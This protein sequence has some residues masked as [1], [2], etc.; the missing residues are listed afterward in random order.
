MAS[1][2]IDRPVFSWVIAI[3]IMLAG[4]LSISKIP[5]E[6]YPNIAPPSVVIRA[7]YPGASS[8][9]IEN[10]VTQVIEQKLTG[11]DNLRYFI[12]NSADNSSRITLTFEPGT[13]PNIAQIQTQNKIQGA[14]SSLP[15]QVQSQGVFVT[16]SNDSFLLI[17]GLY[18]KDGSVSQKELADVSA[19]QLQD[20]VARVNGVGS[21]TVFGE[22][23]AIRIWLDPNKLLK[24]K[25]TAS[26]IRNA[27][28]AQN[29]DISAGQL[30]G[31]PATENQKI[32][33]AIQVQA[34]LE[35]PE[36]FDKIILKSNPD[37]SQIKL[38]DVARVEMGSQDYKRIVRYKRLPATGIAV[39]LASG[40]NA[41]K[42]AQRVKDTVAKIKGS[43]PEGV[44]VIYPFDTTPFIKISIR[45]VV[46]TLIEAIILVFLVMLLF[47]Q[48]LR[49][50]FIPTIAV[51]V[52]LLGTFAI[53]S[54]F[55]FSINV[56]TMFAMVL[57]IGLL[58]DDA[59]VVVEN[60]ERIMS[61]EGLPP[62][63]AT[64]KSMQQITPALIGIALVLSSVF[65]PMAFFSGA[66][67]E[68]YKQFSITIVSAMLLS[69]IVAIILSP[70]LCATLL[71]S[72]PGGKRIYSDTGFLGWFNKKFNKTRDGYH[73]GA[74]SFIINPKR[75]IAIYLAI[76]LVMSIMFVRLPTAFLPNE[77]QGVMYLLIK[78]PSGSPANRTLKSVKKVEDYF[79]EKEANN[80]DHLF[81]VTGF[82]FSGSAQN[83][84]FGFIGLKNWDE[85]PDRDQSVFAISGRS[86]PS[87]MKIKDALSFS[88][89][90]PPIREL[91]VESGFDF[92][93]VDRAGL[94]HKTVMNARN[95]ML[96]MAA[97][98]PKIV[99]IRP[100]GL[101][102]VAQY[103]INVDYDKATTLGVN[104][105]DIHK[106]L[107]IAFGSEYVNDFI[108]K[109][110]VKKVLI[111]ADAPHRMMPDD[112]KKWYVRNNKGRMVSL[113]EFTSGEWVRGSL[114]LERFNG[115]KALNI[116]GGPAPGVST[117]E[118]MDEL[119]EMSKKLPNG[120][121]LQWSGI[122]YEEQLGGAQAP[123]LYA[124]SILIVFLCLAALYESWI[125]PFSVL[126]TI[127]IGIFGATIITKTFHLNNSIYF[128][129]ALLTTIG[130]TAKNA[131]LIVEFAKKLYLETGDLL[132]STLEACKTRFRPIIMTSFAFILGVTPLAT[133][134]GAGS[135]AQNAIGLAVMGGMLA[136]TFIAIFFVPL[137]FILIER[138][139]NK[140]KSDPQPHQKPQNW[141]DNKEG[142]EK[143]AH[144]ISKINRDNKEDEEK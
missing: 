115:R 44:E 28:A 59:I 40:E 111:Q 60:V 112:V 78:S 58:V 84:A 69:V 94:G 20:S 142:Q 127:P 77:D 89:F 48:N 29:I 74:K 87:L 36:Q 39:S 65:V 90:P 46:K 82:S 97:Q 75:S 50:T 72:E 132:E 17:I 66:A 76:A 110:R 124:L 15:P 130:L 137:F 116:V 144:L 23:H 103:K 62:K 113:A 18:S 128:Q 37:G 134:S 100:N 5:V 16:K 6:Q 27:V 52:V 81:T 83:T 32:N 10:S 91:G 106:T 61:R 118:A 68:I 133:A 63:E 92:Y 129:V 4:I 43:F 73:D 104:I 139:I 79:L 12:S 38:A 25:I 3:V 88:F 120:I 123:L 93:L 70:S 108:D 56:L 55:G 41:I 45:E 125:I 117:G 95:Q 67:G 141:L 119:L 13:D 54:Q 109:S 35:N 80:I 26:D 107:Q 24:Y 11:I 114:K 21:V 8:E 101:E 143:I 7:S 19:S 105:S 121:D 86:F 42:T 138:L 126:L 102:D 136:A 64:K 49:A 1:F 9:V 98:N 33:A 85:R 31:L 51:P 53:L 96:G 57:A 22:P 30:G 140:L 135:A 2:F 34:K 47:L 14:I 71:K 122:S 131:I 99:G